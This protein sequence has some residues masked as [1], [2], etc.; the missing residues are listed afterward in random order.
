VIRDELGLDRRRAFATVVIGHSMHSPDYD[1][2]DMSEFLRIYNSHLSRIEVITY[3][4]QL[5][6]ADRALDITSPDSDA[7][8]TVETEQPERRLGHGILRPMGAGSEHHRMA[9]RAPVLVRPA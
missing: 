5:A 6:G 1:R 4:D 9:R 2:Y 8:P 3:A 7:I